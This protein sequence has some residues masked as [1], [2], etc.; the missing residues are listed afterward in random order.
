MAPDPQL[1]VR[2]AEDLDRLEP[3]DF[4]QTLLQRVVDSVVVAAGAEACGDFY[5]RV[6]AIAADRTYLDK[7]CLVLD[8][9]K[10]HHDS[11]AV[12]PRFVDFLRGEMA[13][14]LSFCALDDA[15]LMAPSPDSLAEGLRRS[16]VR[17][18]RGA[19]CDR[20]RPAEEGSHEGT[21]TTGRAR[22]RGAA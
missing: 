20:Y 13:T 12:F 17:V 9:I 22:R 5:A 7:L 4:V 11:A 8:D 3:A 19:L 14:A 21:L 2:L 15:P 10:A 16:L 18:G 6:A 1:A